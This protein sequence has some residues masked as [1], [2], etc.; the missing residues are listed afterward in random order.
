[1]N[2]VPKRNTSQKYSGGKLLFFVISTPLHGGDRVPFAARRKTIARLQRM[3]A[4]TG[5]GQNKSAL[6][7]QSLWE[8]P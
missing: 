2:S 4:E 1:M 5:D 3:S 7:H 6:P 8:K